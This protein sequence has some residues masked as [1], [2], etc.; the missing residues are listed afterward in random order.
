MTQYVNPH[1]G[2][3]RTL[4]RITPFLGA[5]FL[6]P[7]YFLAKGHWPACL[8]MAVLY[9]PLVAVWPLLLFLQFIVAFFAGAIMRRHYATRGFEVAA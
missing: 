7:V 1:T 9:A 4:G 5:L 2:Q 8:I 6:G 3:R